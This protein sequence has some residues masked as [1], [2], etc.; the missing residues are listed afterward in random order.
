MSDGGM[1]F[2]SLRQM[3]WPI[4]QALPLEV[5][6]GTL[7]VL[8]GELPHWSAPNRTARSRH[9]YTLHVVDG[10]ATYSQDNWLQRPEDDSFRGF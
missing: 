4:E 6:G 9:A 5:P 8:H 2:E 10:E 7:V 1:T 3:E